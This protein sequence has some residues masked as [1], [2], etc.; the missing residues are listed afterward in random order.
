MWARLTPYDQPL[1]TGGFH[2]KDELAAA[3]RLFESQVYNLNAYFN[4]RLL[5][6]DYNNLYTTYMQEKRGYMRSRFDLTRTLAT[7][8]HTGAMDA[9]N[10][11][12]ISTN[13]QR[14]IANLNNRLTFLA[15]TWQVNRGLLGGVTIGDISTRSA[16]HQEVLNNLAKMIGAQGIIT[17]VPTPN[18]A[19][20][21]QPVHYGKSTSKKKYKKKYY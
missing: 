19:G 20:D 5:A 2:D 14:T 13:H 8:T 6:D 3:W 18:I 7:V 15:E 21:A 11:Y 17:D 4:F 16:F 9:F 10:N 1:H 12:F